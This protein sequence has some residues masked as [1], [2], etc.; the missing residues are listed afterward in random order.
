MRICAFIMAKDEEGI[1]GR[2]V[3]SAREL[4]DKVLV[5][6]TGSSDSTADNAMLAGASVRDVPWQGFG[7]TLTASYAAAREVYGADWCLRLDADMTIEAHEGLAEWLAA[8]PDPSVSAWDVEIVEPTVRWCLPL[9]MRADRD[10]QYVGATHEY[11]D[12]SGANVRRLLGLTVIHHRDSSQRADKL[13][14]DLELLEPGF[15]AGDARATFYYAETLSGLGRIDEAVEA[16][17]LRVGLGAWDQERWFASFRIAELTEDVDGLLA[18]H[19]ERP[20][21]HE[22]LTVASKLVAA[23]ENPDVLFNR[24]WG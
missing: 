18:C 17:R 13:T 11:L 7:P 6:D 21:R 15:L 23:G 24:P 1:V 20:W 8:D 10:W 2:A 16:Y 19:R 9:L 12:V 4:T 3:A 14:R 22:P 5:C